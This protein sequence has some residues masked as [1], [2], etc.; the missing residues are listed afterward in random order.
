MYL[1]LFLNT[2]KVE[3]Q[4]I[5]ERL[6]QLKRRFLLEKCLTS[7]LPKSHIRT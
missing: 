1:L 6:I 2:L 5:Q 3:I 4:H 7:R